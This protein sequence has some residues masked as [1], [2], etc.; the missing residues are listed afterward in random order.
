[1]PNKYNRKH[2]VL[3]GVILP[4]F[5]LPV[6]P[7]LCR[8]HLSCS[9]DGEI[10]HVLSYIVIVDQARKYMWLG[11]DADGLISALAIIY[12]PVTAC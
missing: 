9:D 11:L 3:V 10:S 8:L 7:V 5:E 1:M 6:M 12:I 4:S 2:L